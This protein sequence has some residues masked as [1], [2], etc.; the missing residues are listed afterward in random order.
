MKKYHFLS[1]VLIVVFLVIIATALDHGRNVYG[2]NQNDALNTSD[3]YNSSGTEA[4]SVCG[5]ILT[6]TTWTLAESP[7]TLTCDVVITTGVSLNIA[8][9]VVVKGQSDVEL[10][11]LG[12]L[13]A[14]GKPLQPITFTSAADSG[15]DEWQGL[16][17]DGGTGDLRHVTVRYGGNGNSIVGLDANGWDRG[18]NIAVRGV[19]DGQVRIESSRVISEHA[20]LWTG[21]VD[22]YSEDY[23]LYVENSHVVVS[24]TLFA[25]NGTSSNDYGAVDYGIYIT[26]TQTVVTLTANTLQDNH[27]WAIGVQPDSLQGIRLSDNTASGNGHNRV[28]VA[29]GAVVD[30][31]NLVP[32]NLEGYELEGDLS[33]L[34]GTTFTVEPGA[35]VMGRSESELR[36]F[37]HL[38][39]VGTEE[40]SILFTSAD[41]NGPDGWQG[42]VFDGGSGDLRHVTVR[43]GGNGNSIVGLDSNGWA[44]GSNIAVRDVSV[45]QVRIESSEV[46]DEYAYHY[47][48]WVDRYP[49]DYGLYVENSHVI[50]SDTLFTANGSNNSDHA[51]YITGTGTVLIEN[52]AVVNNPGDGLYMAHV[53]PDIKGSL[54][55]DNEIGVRTADGSQPTLRDNAIFNNVQYGIQNTDASVTVDALGN[56]WGSPSGPYHPTTNPGGMGNQVSDHV[57][58][59]PW[60]T[61]PVSGTL[62]MDEML[63]SLS[64]PHTASPGQTA[65]YA[66]YYANM[67]T[68]TVES[69][70]V[71]ITLPSASEYVDST[72]DGILWPER[73]QV[74]WKLGDLA[75][76]TAGR[77]SVRA[78]FL[79]GLPRGLED[80]VMV[81]LAG[82][83]LENCP[84]D[85]SPYLAY[86][87]REV[88]SEVSLTEAQ[89]NGERT[90]YPDLDTIYTQALGD[91]FLF[92]DASRLHVSSGDVITQ[93]VLLD[94]EQRAIMYLRRQGDQVRAST[95]DPTTYAVR[96]ATGGIEMNTQLNTVTYWGSWA[97]DAAGLAGQAPSG[98]LSKGECFLNCINEKLP[99]WVVAKKIKAIGSII[100]AGDCYKCYARGDSSACTK[101]AGAVRGIPGVGE[102]VDTVG[103]GK[104]C[105]EDPDSHKC[106]EDKITCDQSW[107]NIYH[108][109]GVSNYKRVRCLNGRYDPLPQ[110]LTCAYGDKCVEGKG[111]V[112]CDDHPDAC[113]KQ[114]TDIR[115]AHD[116]NAKYG[117]EADLLPGQLVT[118][119]ITY[120][121][122]GA[123]TAY[124]VFVAD[125]LSEHFE[126]STVTL[127]G[128]GE[129]VEGTNLLLWQV[130]DLASQEEGTVSLTVRLKDDLPGGTV[131]VN[132]AV[133]HFP[134][135][136]E[137]TPTN[138]MVNVIQTISALP[139]T[140]EAEA[141]QPVAVTLQGVDVGGAPLSYSVA[142][143]PLYGELTGV[144]PTLVYTPLTTFSGLDRFSFRV[145]NGVTESRLAEVGIQVIPWSGDTTPPEVLWTEP[146]DEVT[147][148]EVSTSPVLT[149][150]TGPAYAP[151]I[152][153]QFSEVISSTTI[154]ADTVRMKDSSGQ[155]V[156]VSVTYD[157]TSNQAVVMPREPLQDAS[158]TVMIDQE[159]KDMI[160]NSMGD[161]Y[162]WGFA[163]GSPSTQVYLPIVL[164]SLT[165]APSGWVT[166]IDETFEGD[167]P[168]D[169]NLLDTSSDGQEYYWGKKNCRAYEGQYSAWAIG[170]GRDGVQLPCFSEYSNN[171]RSWMIYGPFSLADAT[172]GDLTLR[173]WIHAEYTDDDKYDYLFRGF[174]INGNEFYGRRTSGYSQGAWITETLDLTDIPTLG[175]IT[176]QPQVWFALL[177]VSDGSTYAPEGVHVDNILLRKYVSDTALSISEDTKPQSIDP[178][179]REVLRR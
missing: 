112:D 42:L 60:L 85:V 108:L 176:G 67:T 102:T 79:W 133:V 166:I 172:A 2:Q 23:G 89:V 37:G 58:F 9:E 51:I 100:N 122:E 41:D 27:D 30:G 21:Y 134:S 78:R 142:E 31:A 149:D 126:E 46:R 44:R 99:S 125:E 123:G 15:P 97:P 81:L 48:G 155:P 74:F 55:F 117:S 169:W 90:A 178:P 158:Y 143:Q 69:A 110:I 119:T 160:G 3:L 84:F 104:D 148:S 164:R 38:D 165:T 43:Y 115:I 17:F 65:H 62:L 128:G 118:Y 120:E 175:D 11:V 68:R 10:K 135:V 144:A 86:V 130:G 173:F 92:G 13:N 174:S 157:G 88:L 57:L 70:V 111:C 91:G 14:V 64:A 159:V 161:D 145:S 54:I 105:L 77:V 24:D 66:I 25:Y 28:L 39:A 113:A 127:Y 56:W 171:V 109:M 33:V 136:P 152:I 40:Q 87:P 18:S 59:E 19:S 137:K 29:A 139:Q 35:V 163:V 107:W 32:T 16:V 98:F 168:G 4:A 106:T 103:C 8:P 167:F 83:N 52:T 121:N 50:I 140:V 170:G 61:Q 116:P 26:G 72:G 96:D 71:L 132:Q 131:I 138:P 151:F 22:R 93:V 47:T 73:H 177:F 101:C 7:Y 141:G 162:S 124:D 12:H 82:Q 179:A 147:I 146:K 129:R 75:P 49:E 95:F 153:A 45:G 53:S 150:A 114:S 80:T 6:D 63:F 1:G 154:T 34:T 156:V 36:V 20:Y 5:T 76:G 94:L